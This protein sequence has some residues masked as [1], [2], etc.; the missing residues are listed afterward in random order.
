V[1][2][3]DVDDRRDRL[4]G[5]VLPIGGVGAALAALRAGLRQ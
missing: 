5:L 3:S 2:R 1:V 4:R